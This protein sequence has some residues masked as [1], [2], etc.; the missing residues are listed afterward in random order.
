MRINTGI[1]LATAPLALLASCNKAADTSAAN[2]T[3]PVT[4]TPAGTNWVETTSET[5]D[6]GMLMGNPDAPVKLI[7]YGALSCP[8]C[9]NFS[10]TSRDALKA[11]VAKGTVSYEFRTF[12]IH[13]QDVPASLLARCNGAGPFFAISEQLFDTQDDWLMKRSQTITAAEQQSWSKMSPNDVAAAMGAKLGLIEFVQQ[14]G[15][16]AEKAQACLADKGG[17]TKLETIAKVAQDKFQIQATPTFI[18]NGQT[19][20]DTNNWEQLEPALKAAGA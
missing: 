2:T 4:A 3:A 9:A 13:P 7:E 18:I 15:V 20:K 12:L 10:K 6:F 16:G 14:R 1:I 19:V 11:Y 5:A 8:H 17:V